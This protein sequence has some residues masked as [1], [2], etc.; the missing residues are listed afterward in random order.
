M[1]ASWKVMDLKIEQSVVIKFL[2][3][4]GEKLAKIFLK[5][6]KVFRN[7]CASRAC[8]FKWAHRFKEALWT[9]SIRFLKKNHCPT[10]RIR[11]EKKNCMRRHT[12]FCNYWRY[13]SRHDCSN[14]C[15]NNITIP[16]SG[17]YCCYYNRDDYSDDCS[18]TACDF[19]SSM[20]ARCR[21]LFIRKNCVLQSDDDTKVR[22]ALPGRKEWRAKNNGERASLCIH[23][24]RC[25]SRNLSGAHGV[26]S[27]RWNSSKP[28]VSRAMGAPADG[29]SGEMRM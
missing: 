24:C 29:S 27:R 2:S 16:M 21:S 10:S 12:I 5:L 25:N 23:R 18:T 19:F 26:L 4:S 28:H 15:S 22:T 1:R 7:E 9:K 14:D 11:H 3:D 8:P 20:D 17:S 6:K 13:Y